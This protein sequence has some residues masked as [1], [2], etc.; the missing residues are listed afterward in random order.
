MVRS[1]QP[2]PCS[3]SLVQGGLTKVPRGSGGAA[4]AGRFVSSYFQP[5]KD[6]GSSRTL[7]DLELE[8]AEGEEESLREYLASLPERN[9]AAKEAAR[10]RHEAL[11]GGAWQGAWAEL[12]VHL[13]VWWQHIVLVACV[14]QPSLHSAP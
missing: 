7:A 11:V 10:K 13:L 9:A 2:S 4:G 8:A 14:L 12:C 6:V 5:Q 3:N 1:Q